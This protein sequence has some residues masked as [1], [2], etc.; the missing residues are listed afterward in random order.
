MLRDKVLGK[1]KGE[2]R[3]AL[4]WI[5]LVGTV[6]LAPGVVFAE[7][8]E[9]VGRT[10]TYAD[11]DH[12]TVIRPAIGV[13]SPLPAN[14]ELGVG[15][16]VDIITTASIDVVTQATAAE[17]S[18]RRHEIGARLTRLDPAGGLEVGG[19]FTHSNEADYT[20]NAVGFKASRDFFQRNTTVSGKAGLVKDGV[21]RVDSPPFEESLTGWGYAL[22]ISQILSRHL[23]LRGGYEGAYLSGFQQ[24]PYR[25]VRFGDFTFQFVGGV[26]VFNGVTAVREEIHPE[27]RLRHTFTS[28]A[29][30]YVGRESALQ[31]SYQFYFDDWGVRSH[32][33]ELRWLAQLAERVRL[34]SGYRLYLQGGADFYR[35]Q[36]VED[37][38]QYEFYTVDK[39]LGRLHGHRVGVGIEYGMSIPR[40][41]AALGSRVGFNANVD[42]V[43]NRYLEF[44][45]LDDRSAF[46]GQFGL[47]VEQ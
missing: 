37:P 5:L 19:S 25:V 3:A 26:P 6:Q 33:L 22:G 42:W 39:R 24:S 11:S 34:Q 20:S 9:V 46:V 36:Y 4:L 18:D 13:T 8:E 47:F 35:E 29:A 14:L 43:W 40:R 38:S 41:R 28:G 15:Y 32:E 27:T 16:S 45:F 1:K 21:F 44:L 30:W 23:V 7:G 12:T 17:F 10:E 2:S 31:P